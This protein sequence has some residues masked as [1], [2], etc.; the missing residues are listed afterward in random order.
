MRS[1]ASIYQYSSVVFRSDLYQLK[2]FPS[3]FKKYFPVYLVYQA[4]N[5]MLRSLMCDISL[6]L[7]KGKLC[8]LPNLSFSCAFMAYQ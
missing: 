8:V 1:L 4:H 2:I 7:L 5:H 6:R 3:M